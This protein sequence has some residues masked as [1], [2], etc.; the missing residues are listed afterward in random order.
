M[1]SVEWLKGLFWCETGPRWCG[2]VVKCWTR[3]P[4][5]MGSMPAMACMDTLLII[6]SWS[7]HFSSIASSFDE[8]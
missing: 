8:V 4:N 2:L 1:C 7:S 3:D 5:I 6:T